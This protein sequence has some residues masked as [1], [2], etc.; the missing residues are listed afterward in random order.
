MSRNNAA[1]IESLKKISALALLTLFYFGSGKLGLTL[2][3][4]NPSATAVW[5]PTGIALA[6]L[7]V[8]GYRAW[9]AILAGAFL[10]NITTSGSVPASLMIAGGN[11][12]EALAAAYLVNRYANGRH[13]FERAQDI[14]RFIVLA[15]LASTAIS[16]TIG[17]G[18]LVLNGLATLSNVPHIW[19]T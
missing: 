5:P 6:A 9:P 16:A 11:T 14:F 2:A 12:L 3:I 7:L 15:G 8:L 1:A 10:V 18:S 13:V 4:V 17:V 19:L